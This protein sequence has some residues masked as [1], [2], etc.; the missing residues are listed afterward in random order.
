[1]RETEIK[2]VQNDQFFILDFTLTANDGTAIDLT[3]SAI[4]I[5]IQNT[6]KTSLKFTGQMVIT[7]AINGKCKYIVQ[8]G[9]FDQPGKY[10][11]QI[12]VTFANNEILTF[13]DLLI[14]ALPELPK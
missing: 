2:V 13:T 11:G 7:D 9:D 5:E 3:G 14:R 1:M 8:P 4:V 10:Y 6:S 12:K